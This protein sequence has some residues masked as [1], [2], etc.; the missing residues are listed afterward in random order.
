VTPNFYTLFI[1][2]AHIILC[3]CV[4]SCYRTVYFSV[5]YIVGFV[6]CQ[7]SIKVLFIDWLPRRPIGLTSN[8]GFV[9]L[10][11]GKH[12]SETH[13][14]SARGMA[15]C[16]RTDGRTDGSQRCLVLSTLL[17]GAYYNRPVCYTRKANKVERKRQTDR[18][19]QR[20]RRTRRDHNGN[21]RGC[22]GQMDKLVCSRW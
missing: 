9:L 4:I 11:Y 15:S 12:N 3:F 7:S 8:V 2:S 5:Y 13:R 14:F 17:V 16:R 18:Q 1:L 19:R 22:D 10:F 6:F 20:Q 21:V